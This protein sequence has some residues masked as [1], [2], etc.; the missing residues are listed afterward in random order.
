MTG[1]SRR[2][3]LAAGTGGVLLAGAAGAELVAQGL[4]PGK[5]YLDEVDGACSVPP[6][7]EHF[8]STGPTLTGSFFSRARN[9]QVRFTLAY[10][11]GRGPESRLPLVIY[12]YGNGG[13]HTTPLGGLP[14]VK[15]LAGHTRNGAIPPMAL[16]VADGGSLYWNA[17]PGDDPMR[18][19][20]EELVP[21]LRA[22][23]LGDQPKSIGIIGISMGGYGALLLTEK[24]PDLFAATAAIS[25]AIWTSY[26]EARSANPDAFATAA[27]FAEDDVITH[28]HQ[29]TGIPVRIA[30]G[31]DDPFHPGVLALAAHLPPTV[32][33]H[34]SPGCHDTGFFSEQQLPSLQFLGEHLTT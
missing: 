22:R 6:P 17:H 18:M 4:L 15:A 29:L 31:A 26:G 27:E 3:F 21:R 34:I 28:A 2:R 30:S 23:R 8:G 13:S 33:L 7:A 9:R 5:H 24:R 12:L 10:P 16:V 25:P 1:V 19:I 32:S 20:T 11:P 14:V